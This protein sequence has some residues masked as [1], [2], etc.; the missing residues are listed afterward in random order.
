[1]SFPRSFQTTHD[2]CFAIRDCHCT[3]HTVDLPRW[4]QPARRCR[5]DERAEFDVKFQLQVIVFVDVRCRGNECAGLLVPA[6]A[7]R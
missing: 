7:L 3:A 1:M 6:E 4:R 5:T 2:H